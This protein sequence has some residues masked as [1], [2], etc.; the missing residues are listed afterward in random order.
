MTESTGTPAVTRISGRS[1]RVSAS[2]FHYGC[3]AALL[4]PIPL[5]LLWLGASIVV[6]AMNR[7]HPNPKVGHYTQRMAYVFYGVAGF[8]V[9]VA[10]F[11]SGTSW[12]P[13][14]VAWAIGA[15]IVI[16]WAVIELFRIRRESWEDLTLE[17]QP[18]QI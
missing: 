16:P 6:Y 14:V 8:F 10:I 9:A 1:A 7:H 2:L 15:L 4:L 18:E 12:L 5:G 17:S 11:F 3:I 13:Y